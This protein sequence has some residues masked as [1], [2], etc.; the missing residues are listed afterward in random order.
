MTKR[1]LALALLGA[2]CKKE[3]PPPPVLAP[4]VQVS[5]RQALADALALPPGDVQK[6]AIHR[7]RLAITSEAAGGPVEE[8]PEG[9]LRLGGILWEPKAQKLSFTAT[10]T[11]PKADPE[12]GVE[13]AMPLEVICCTPA[14]RRYESLLVSEVRPLHLSL[15]LALAGFN[16]DSRWQVAIANLDQSQA[17]SAFLPKDQALASWSFSPPRMSASGFPPDVSGDLLSLEFGVLTPSQ[18]PQQ[19]EKLIPQL[20]SGYTNGSSVIV[21][22]RPLH[23]K[24]L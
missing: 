22:I 11:V 20:P 16:P 19:P 4:A 10:L 7:A 8:G 24:I 5:P 3:V 12:Q 21:E 14:G 9:S 23:L 2:S 6:K 13:Q 1:L 17:L 15:L 18:A